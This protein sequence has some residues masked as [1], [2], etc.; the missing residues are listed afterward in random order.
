MTLLS[1]LSLE[2]FQMKEWTKCFTQYLSTLDYRQ[3]SHPLS[4]LMSLTSNAQVNASITLRC[5]NHPQMQLYFTCGK[6]SAK[7]S[8]GLS[9]ETV[10]PPTREELVRINYKY[11]NNAQV[12]SNLDTSIQT[13]AF[14]FTF[15]ANIQA[16]ICVL[17]CKLLMNQ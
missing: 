2:L 16:D 6:E 3:Q 7:I 13:Q 8:V 15:Y 17:N 11:Y 4:K 9:I 10:V 1:Y 5:V 14:K 12:S